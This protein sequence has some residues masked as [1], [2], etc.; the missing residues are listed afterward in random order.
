M[1]RVKAFFK[2]N[3]GLAAILFAIMGSNIL[4]FN[5]KG[6]LMNPVY[7]AGAA[8][9]FYAG[10]RY[11]WTQRKCFLQ[12]R[13]WK[14]SL[15]LGLLFSAMVVVGSKITAENVVFE[16]FHIA[17]L[18]SFLF[19]LVVGCLLFFDLYL[20]SE[21]KK[22]TG[23]IKPIE[24]KKEKSGKK[25]WLIYSI[26]LILAWI[27]VFITY[28]PGIMPEDA[29]VSVAISMGSL[30]W[31]NHFPVFYTLIVGKLI[32]IGDCLLHDVNLGI[33]LYSVLQMVIMAGGLGY[34]LYWLEKKGIRKGV[35]YLGLAYFAAAPMFGNY[36]IVMWK[37]P[38]FSELLI[39]LAIFLYE[40]TVEDRMSFL[41]GR[42]LFYYAV[43]IVL[44]CLMRNNGIYIAVL[45]TL[46]LLIVYRKELKKVLPVLVG[47]IFVVWFITGPV[48]KHVFSA[49]NV[50]V[51]SIGIPLQQMARTVVMG[52][53]MDQEDREFMDHLLPLEK[54][55]EYYSPNLVD[56]IKWAPEFDTPYLD[57]H[58][59]EF[60]KTWWSMLLKNFDLY[61]EQYLMGTYGYW[62]IGGD[63]NYELVKVEVTGND[64]GM[65]Q[66]SPFETI[67][68][69]PMK[70][71]LNGKYDYIASGLL[72][73]AVLVNVVLCWMKKR[74]NYIIPLLGMVGNWLTL[75]VATPTAFGVRYIFVCVIG[76]PLLMVYPWLIPGRK[77]DGQK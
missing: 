21:D 6:W 9:V 14:G 49:E 11:A 34:L 64:W 51:E 48:Y 19:Y 26:I 56:Y 50:F 53:E 1:K 72:V 70:E 58:K 42:N 13:I 12:A 17:D 68:G 24:E 69:Y 71:T 23:F 55:Q 65:Y 63:T 18:F 4:F 31:D 75:M 37:D 5:Q 47:S 28:Y 39:L 41:K 16:A 67:L 74:G 73:W 45:I 22:I 46:Y 77:E 36:A 38:W 29:S 32:Y 10:I 40:H 66:S 33:A 3:E 52:G 25:N 61:V 7:I 30:P 8:I 2:E 35:L 54:Y 27:P 62:H 43:L 44:M 60:F 15:I 76:L 20:L 59:K 57:A